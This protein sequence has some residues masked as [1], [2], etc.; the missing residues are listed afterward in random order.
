MALRDK[1]N[2]RIK[3]VYSWLA[4]T[5]AIIAILIPLYILKAFSSSNTLD[6][7]EILTYGFSGFV[8]GL[9]CSY[10]CME[11]FNVENFR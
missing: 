7:Q 1:M 6:I 9:F 3:I 2:L 10:L 11:K 8:G 5:G 4:L